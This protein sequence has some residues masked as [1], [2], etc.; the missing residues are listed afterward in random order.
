MYPNSVK[1]LPIKRRAKRRHPSGWVGTPAASLCQFVASGG[2]DYVRYQSFSGLSSL[3]GEPKAH[4]VKNKR[5][6]DY[7]ETGV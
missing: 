4:H 1:H 7:Q 2:W 3:D 6:K 5:K